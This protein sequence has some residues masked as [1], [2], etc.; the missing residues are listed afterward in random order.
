LET[1]FLLYGANGYTG[2]LIAREAVARGLRPTLAGRNRNAI[3]QSAR[4]LGCPARIFSLSRSDVGAIASQLTGAGA[5]LNCAG[6]FAETAETLM[7]ACVA[8]GVHY[9]DI[10]G[11]IDVIEAAARRDPA[12]KVREIVLLPAV[13][14]DVVPTDCLAAMLSARLPSATHLELAF[15]TSGGMSQG[16]ANTALATMPRGGRTRVD[17]RIIKVPVAWKMKNVPFSDRSRWAT[18]IPWG[19][20]SSAYYSTGIPNIEVYMAASR[21]GIRRMRW[22]RWLMP[23]LRIPAVRHAIRRRIVRDNGPSEEAR[24]AGRARLW[25]CVRDDSGSQFT[26]TLDTLEGYS[27][28][29]HTALES[30]RR[31]LAGDVSTGFKTPSRAFGAEFILTM[32]QT[33]VTI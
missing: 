21:R 8:A 33:S 9:L 31:V 25:G 6:P 10:T 28:T 3:E 13:G 29:V 24:R 5:V 4:E 18:T 15:A 19:D 1:T 7:D 32:P 14:F 2:E 26:A 11:E 22:S 12:A 17:G 23:L 20:V 30:V 27:L 16:T